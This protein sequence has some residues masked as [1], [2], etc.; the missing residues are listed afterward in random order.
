MTAEGYIRCHYTS[1]EGIECGSWLPRGK[2]NLC[3][4]HIGMV[5]ASL[6]ANGT[7]K[8]EFLEA[9]KLSQAPLRDLIANKDKQ[10]QCNIID[11]HL[12]RVYKIIEEQKLI[13][14]SY[15]AL[16][17]EVIEG[18]SLEEIQARRL[19]KVPKSVGK[20][21][22]GRISAKKTTEDNIKALL[23]KNPKMTEAG[24]RMLLGLD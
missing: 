16:R 10:E 4:V 5:S 19:M 24:A 2:G 17:G 20:P 8:D 6:A 22:A 13:A 18:M 21:S 12:A 7:N 15:R 14:S 11:A 3:P 1:P 9:A 23:A